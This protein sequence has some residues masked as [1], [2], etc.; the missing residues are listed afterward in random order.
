MKT[1]AKIELLKEILQSKVEVIVMIG[2]DDIGKMVNS[3]QEI[4]L[5]KEQ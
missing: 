1:R 3:V 5:K 4:L 2:A